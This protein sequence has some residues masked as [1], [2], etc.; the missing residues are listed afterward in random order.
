MKFY[1][2][3]IHLTIFFFCFSDVVAINMGQVLLGHIGIQEGVM[4]IVRAIT[5]HK[6]QNGVG[7]EKIKKKKAHRRSTEQ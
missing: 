5:G 7:L 3:F 4:G 2:V 6:T 1:Q